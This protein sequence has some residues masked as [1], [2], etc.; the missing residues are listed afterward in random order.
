VA[1]NEI[2]SALQRGGGQR[3]RAVVGSV[4]RRTLLLLAP[5]VA[6]MITARQP[7]VALLYERGA[8]GSL[9]VERTA[10]V[11]GFY[12]LDV[13]P[14]FVFGILLRVLYATE[15]PWAATLPTVVMAVVAGLSDWILIRAIGLQAIPVGYGI[16]IFAGI[17]A[18]LVQIRMHLGVQL[19]PAVLRST[20][21]S[22]VLASAGAAV[23][24][25]I[26][27]WQ[28]TEGTGFGWALSGHGVQHSLILGALILGETLV[29]ATVALFCGRLWGM[30]EV[31]EL[32]AD[33]RSWRSTA[34][35]GAT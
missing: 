20:L 30:P 15:R 21:V 2:V 28:S 13:M 8:F 26:V 23:V 5:L 10:G 31:S 4:L 9:S 18:A 6:I 1:F 27:R 34:E 19:T 11:F 12:A 25:L 16:G 33:L 32:L 3:V 17:G 24:V 14:V 35:Q 7:I 29:V 22:S